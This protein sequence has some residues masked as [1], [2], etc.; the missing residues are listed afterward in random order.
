MFSCLV[1]PRAGGRKGRHAR[2]NPALW[3]IIW[4]RF[5]RGVIFCSGDGKSGGAASRT[6]TNTL[7]RDYYL[8][9]D[10]FR[11]KMKLDVTDLRYV[12]SEEFRVLT[13]V[14]AHS[15]L[16]V[17]LKNGC[18]LRRYRSRSVLKITRLYLPR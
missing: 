8:T 18:L 5:I 16:S 4:A 13:A 17:D 1:C 10:L 11:N 12:S 6:Q 15:L 7:S 3:Q 9:L 2:W 14:R